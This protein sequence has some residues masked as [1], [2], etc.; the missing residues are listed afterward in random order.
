MSS[1][2]RVMKRPVLALALVCAGIPLCA[3]TVR[4]KARPAAGEMVA[5]AAVGAFAVTIAPTRSLRPEM[6]PKALSAVASSHGSDPGFQAWIKSF[7][8]R[9]ARAGVHGAVFDRAFAGVRFDPEVVAKDSKQSEFTKPIWDYLDTAASDARVATGREMMVKHG[10][11]LRQLEEQYGVDRQIILAIWGMETNFGKFRG[12]NNVVQSMASLAY[13]GRRRGFFEGELIAALK[14]LQA[15][16]T[17]PEN[18]K[19][20]WAGA[21]GHTQFM[22]S[23]FNA[24]AVDFTGDGRR[25]IWGEDPADALASTANYLAKSGWVTHMPWGVE[26]QLPERFDFALVGTAEKMPSDWA[27]LGVRDIKGNP[28]RDYGAAR[29]LLPAGHQGAAFLV[30]KNFRVIKRYNAADA[31]ALG[32]GHLGDRILGLPPITG[33]WPRHDRALTV[34]ERKE[35]QRRLTAAGYDTRGVDGRLGPN[36]IAA[37]RRWQSARGL[38]PDGFASFGTLQRLQ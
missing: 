10:R 5:R 29:L 18:M 11:L 7:R 16:H 9:A 3:E 32:V 22:P 20:S 8:P 25:D 12:S 2:N 1:Q 24:L 37:L 33:E 38:V 14:I 26:V 36:S 6:R 15:G 19:G 27:R 28:V 35:L 30:F 13:D 34:S 21:M 4:P 23:S 17:A 31:Y